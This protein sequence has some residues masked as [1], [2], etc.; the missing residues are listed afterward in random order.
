VILDREE[1]I[2]IDVWVLGGR[3]GS[4]GGSEWKGRRKLI[5]W[6]FLS[7]GMSDGLPEHVRIIRGRL[8]IF[9]PVSHTPIF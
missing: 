4:I 5:F 2:L 6:S 1:R 8:Y 3:G 9:P 7:H